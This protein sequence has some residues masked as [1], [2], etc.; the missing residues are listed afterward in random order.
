MKDRV[1]GENRCLVS[2]HV[3]LWPVLV[4]F[5]IHTYGNEFFVRYH[6]IPLS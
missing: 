5:N 1:G 4:V 6:V 2:A 3:T